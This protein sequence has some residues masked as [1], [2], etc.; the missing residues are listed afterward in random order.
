VGLAVRQTIQGH[1][2]FWLVLYLLVVGTA[3]VSAMR[4]LRVVLVEVALRS[5]VLAVPVQAV[6]VT[7]V[8]TRL[9]VLAQLVAVVVLVLWVPVV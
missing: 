4:A 3:A 8:A 5:L 7:P 1:N 2:L 9:V 6:K